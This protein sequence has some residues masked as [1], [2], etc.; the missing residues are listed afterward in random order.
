LS[1]SEIKLLRVGFSLSTSLKISQP[2]VHFLFDDPY[3]E[4]GAPFY[5]AAD[6]EIDVVIS[7]MPVNR[8]D[9]FA[10]AFACE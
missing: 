3:V 1:D 5:V 4:V 10:P 9:Y 6:A 2:T 8:R 7:R